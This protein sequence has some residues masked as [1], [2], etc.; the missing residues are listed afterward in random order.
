MKEKLIPALS[1]ILSAAQEKIEKSKHGELLTV[2]TNV[3]F[4]D[5]RYK[6]SPVYIE[7]KS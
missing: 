3:S 5:D 1:E 2:K 7:G 4:I 6:E